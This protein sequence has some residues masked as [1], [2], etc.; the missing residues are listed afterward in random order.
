MTWAQWAA[1]AERSPWWRETLHAL[2]DGAYWAWLVA[3]VAAVAVWI[4]RGMPSPATAAAVAVAAPLGAGAAA[5][6]AWRL[7]TGREAAERRA[8][9][10]AAWRRW[11][12]LYGVLAAV[13]P[14][15]AAGAVLPVLLAAAVLAELAV[16]TI[17]AR[18]RARLLARLRIGA[19]AVAGGE[20]VRVG[21]ALWR[22]RRLLQV[23]VTYPATWAAH[24]SVRRDELVERLMWELCGPPPRTP[25]EAIARPDYLT[26]WNHI[27]TRLEVY[28]VPPLPRLVPARDWPRPPGALVLGV[29]TADLADLAADDGTPLALYRPAAHLL[30]VGATQH[31]KSSGVR[32]WAVD[33]LTHGLWPGGLWGADGKGSGSLAALIGRRGVHAI[34]HRPDEWRE[35]IAGQVI[36]EVTRRYAEMLAWRSG[37]APTRPHHPRALLILDEIQ[38]I[39]LACPDLADPLNTLARQALEAGVVIWVLTQRPDARDAVPGALRD[40][41]VDRVT[42]GPLSGSG[43]RMAFDIAGEDWHRALGVAPVPGRALSWLDGTWRTIQAPWLPIPADDPA[44][45]PLYPPRDPAG[46]WPPRSSPDRPPTPPRR[47]PDDSGDPS[48]PPPPRRP[49][50]S[51]SAAYDPADP[52]AHRRRRRRTDD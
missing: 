18:A 14:A 30:V 52:H 33:G 7:T 34:A 35:V 32:A 8:A 21:R 36:P 9:A 20:D 22:G 19:A 15:L 3:V 5:A 37:Q 24:K 23:H 38:Q 1:R 6:R 10:G 48:G 27:H 25:A 31:G 13:I 26:G 12:A 40:Q 17:P 2:R 50:A 16:L 47:P 44:A 11:L 46:P 4:G 51:P 29:T 41:L 43:A 28:R 45:D 39:L 49:P 42:F